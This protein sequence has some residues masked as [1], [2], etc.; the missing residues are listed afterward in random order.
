LRERSDDG[1]GLVE[2]LACLHETSR[3]LGRFRRLSEEQMDELSLYCW[4][5]QQSKPTGMLFGRAR[6]LWGAAPRG[7]PGRFSGSRR[8][9][10]P[11]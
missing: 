6:E 8:E 5:L 2:M 3:R 9:R 1:A 4:T 7:R 11:R 10:T